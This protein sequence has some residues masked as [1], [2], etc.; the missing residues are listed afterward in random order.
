MSR[1]RATLQ[2]V[3]AAHAGFE[4][5]HTELVKDYLP[6]VYKWAGVP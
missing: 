1:V 3:R 4:V 5:R 6:G 2:R